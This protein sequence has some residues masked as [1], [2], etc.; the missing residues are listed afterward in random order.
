MTICANNLIAYFLYKYY[1]I[2]N[3]IRNN[4]VLNK[5]WTKVQQV[6]M[7]KFK[8]EEIKDFGY[9]IIDVSHIIYI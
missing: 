2:L 4:I 1:I 6:E 8:D 3:H 5:L 7:I 9:W